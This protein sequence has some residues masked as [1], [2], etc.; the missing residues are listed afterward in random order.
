M[1]KHLWI[2]FFVAALAFLATVKSDA[3]TPGQILWQVGSPDK[4][5]AEFALAPSGYKE[6]KDD[7]FFVVGS[8]DP[9]RD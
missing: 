5:N 4:R 2:A 7:G 6:F 3:A 1:K 8:S 9:K